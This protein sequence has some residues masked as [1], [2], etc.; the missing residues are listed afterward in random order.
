MLESIL[1]GDAFGKIGVHSITVLVGAA[2]GLVV[3]RIVNHVLLDA[4]RNV[5]IFPVY[6]EAMELCSVDRTRLRQKDEEAKN[7]PETKLTDFISNLMKSM[8]DSDDLPYRV[9]RSQM[10]PKLATSLQND[11][12]VNCDI[13]DF[14]GKRDF[15][16]TTILK[17]Q[18]AATV[19]DQSSPHSYLLDRKCQM[20][21]DNLDLQMNLSLAD[22]DIDVSDEAAQAKQE[23]P[24]TLAGARALYLQYDSRFSDGVKNSEFGKLVDVINRTEPFSFKLECWAV[25]AS[26]KE[27]ARVGGNQSFRFMGRRPANNVAVASA[28]R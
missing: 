28:S 18:V 14:T 5:S 25:G 12:I 2:I 24:L 3:P 9:L 13:R 4:S 21:L 20:K 15:V 10:P 17:I 23:M 27:S 1:S 7:A 8:P 26:G 11:G 22:S 19:I 6:V 16:N